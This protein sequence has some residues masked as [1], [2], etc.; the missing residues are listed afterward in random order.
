MTENTTNPLRVALEQARAAHPELVALLD[1]YGEIL[2]AQRAAQEVLPAHT[3]MGDLNRLAEGNPALTSDELAVD[4][5]IFAR[6]WR[7]CDE[8]ARRYH[9]DWP[10]EATPV[11]SRERIREWFHNARLADEHL[12]FLITAAL[13]PFLAR[14]AESIAPHIRQD[15]WMRGVCP[16][17]GGEP[18]FAY[19][20]GDGARHLL[21]QRCD[22]DWLY[23]RVGCPFCGTVEP[24][25]LAYYPSDDDVYRL[26]VCDACRRFLKAIDL[27]RARHRVVWGVER[28]A[29]A[30]MDVAAMQQGYHDST[31]RNAHEQLIQ[32]PAW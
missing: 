2:I 12:E 31:S 22:A 20:D 7:Q 25:Q 10:S 23:H 28:I 3:S 29:T 4:W 30:G 27:R 17:C 11:A 18:D 5:E 24:A 16:V 21:C 26:Y 15:E 13:Y 19:L 1:E 32:P 8:I 9:D 6:L 14:A